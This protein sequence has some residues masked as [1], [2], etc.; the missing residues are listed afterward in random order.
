MKLPKF[1]NGRRWD[2]NT[3]PWNDSPLLY[4]VTTAS[5]LRN[6]QGAMSV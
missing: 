3:I 4:C 6:S 5:H 2:Q 1:R